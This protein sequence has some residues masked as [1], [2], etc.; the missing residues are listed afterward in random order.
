MWGDDLSRI[1]VLSW[2]KTVSCEEH[3]AL[4]LNQEEL[5][6]RLK[7]RDKT[8]SSTYFHPQLCGIQLMS[9]VN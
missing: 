3:G 5:Y 9:G 2:W 8:S 1:E 6:H 4:E 7:A